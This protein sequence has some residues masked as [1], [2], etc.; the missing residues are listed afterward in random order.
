MGGVI[1]IVTS[2]PKDLFAAQ[3]S[4]AYGTYN[5]FQ[6]NLHFSGRSKNNLLYWKIGASIN[7][8][9]GYINTPEEV[10]I[11]NDSIVVPVYLKENMISGEMAYRFDEH[12]LINI[13]FNVYDDIR[14]TGIKIYEDIGAASQHDTYYGSVKYNSVYE[15]IKL[16]FVVYFECVFTRTTNPWF[17]K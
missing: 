11:E 2:K 14:G 4:L 12:N 6:S 8:S 9:D 1:N 10:I 5:T 15:K 13:S 16:F 3:A 17:Y 7:R